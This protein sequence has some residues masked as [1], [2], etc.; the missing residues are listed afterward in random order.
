MT[1]LHIKISSKIILFLHKWFF[2]LSVCTVSF[3]QC[4]TEGSLVVEVKGQNQNFSL[5]TSAQ[6][7]RKIIFCLFRWE[8]RWQAWKVGWRVGSFPPGR[9]T[10]RA[11]QLLI[12]RAQPAP[13]AAPVRIQR[14]WSGAAALPVPVESPRD[15]RGR[16]RGRGRGWVWSWLPVQGGQQEAEPK[17]SA[18]LSVCSARRLG[19]PP[20]ERRGA[21]L[22]RCAL[23][24]ESVP[25]RRRRYAACRSFDVPQRA[26]PAGQLSVCCACRGWLQ[27]NVANFFLHIFCHVCP[28]KV[29]QWKKTSAY[30]KGSWVTYLL[31]TWSVESSPPCRRVED[32]SVW[33]G[34]GWPARTMV[35][36]LV[37]GSGPCTRVGQYCA[38]TKLDSTTVAV[39]IIC[40]Y[41][42]G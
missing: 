4:K 13:S 6:R 26:L 27:G 14:L 22:R 15:C 29:G 7:E 8:S 21:R 24:K 12:C 39:H 3:G 31:V 41:I 42:L 35:S 9:Q 34:S 32:S 37:S 38:G 28:R 5:D 11:S 18:Q 20:S 17:P 10:P 19:R 2:C 30:L 40:V 16:R 33:G 36:P 25:G 23:F 1:S